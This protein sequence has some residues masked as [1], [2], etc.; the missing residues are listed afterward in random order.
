MASPLTTSYR[1][2]EILDHYLIEAHV[3]TGGMASIFRAR[4]TNTG[5]LVA[6][7]VPHS[8]KAGDDP[9]DWLRHETEFGGRFDH[10]G[11]VKTL[12]YSDSRHSYAVMEWVEGRPLREIINEEETLPVERAISITLSICEALEYIHN[13]GVVHRDLKPENVIVYAG[14]NIK[15]LDFGIARETRVSFWRRWK[16][17]DTAGTPAYASPEQIRGKVGDA[18]SDL[19]SLGLMLFEM[20]T[21]EVPFS[22][23]DAGTAMQLRLQL[24]PPQLR[25]INSELSPQLEV[26]VCRTLARDPADRYANVRQL[27]SHLSKCLPHETTAEAL[28][29]AACL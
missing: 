26:V 14:E 28:Q 2:G 9:S 6:I 7:K 1:A 11:L 15:L 17:S 3:A 23:V 21:G 13:R 19:Y 22:G 4:D 10:V 24:D 5:Q 27:A 25:E 8:G 12:A 20:L 18:R 29:S 16:R